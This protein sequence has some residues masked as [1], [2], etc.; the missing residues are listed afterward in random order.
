[1]TQL[2][3]GLRPKRQS[4]HPSITEEKISELV[5]VFYGKVVLNERLGPVFRAH[6]HGDWDEHL[7]KMKTFWRS[8]LLC[9]GEYK[10]KP[11]P[12]HQRI[13]G[14][15]TEDF[16]EWLEL[17]YTA[18]ELVFNEEAA[19]LVNEAARRIAT[20]LWLSR[21]NDPFASPPA[22]PRAQEPMPSA[23]NPTFLC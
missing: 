10:G 21:T 9:T 13:D 22:W 7:A 2:D 1:M 18:T 19:S 12:V 20:S 6:I 8:V 5:E 3:S 4:V 23:D 16:E 17:F 15:E 14:I 11:V